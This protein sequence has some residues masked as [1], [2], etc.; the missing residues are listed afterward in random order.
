MGAR[1]SQGAAN[2]NPSEPAPTMAIDNRAPAGPLPAA[3]GPSE[4]NVALALSKVYW[5]RGQHLWAADYGAGTVLPRMAPIARRY[6]R[7][8]CRSAAAIACRGLR[9]KRAARYCSWSSN[10]ERAKSFST[11]PC[12]TR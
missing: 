9:C 11:M 3:S 5:A 7:S 10:Q 2:T 6:G 4:L 1:S 8:M 12:F